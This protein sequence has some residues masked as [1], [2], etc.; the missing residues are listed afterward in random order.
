LVADDYGVK[1]FGQ[2][3]RQIIMDENERLG[4]NPI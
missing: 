3:I 1:K 2:K 4:V